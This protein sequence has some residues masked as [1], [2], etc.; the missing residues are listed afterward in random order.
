M[1]G[2]RFAC[3]QRYGAKSP[4]LAKKLV[5]STDK[6][7]LPFIAHLR[8]PLGF[9]SCASPDRGCIRI[10]LAPAYCGVLVNTHQEV[11]LVVPAC[12]CVGTTRVPTRDGLPEAA[13][14]IRL[15]GARYLQPRLPSCGPAHPGSSR[16]PPLESVDCCHVRVS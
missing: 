1:G 12:F 5:M 3:P 6:V 13:K 7:V 16:P 14:W 15:R 8:Q 10:A 2:S 9:G 4:R 11:R